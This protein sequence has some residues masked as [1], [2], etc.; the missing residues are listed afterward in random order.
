MMV[1]ACN[2][3]EVV[4]LREDLIRVAHETEVLWS[5]YER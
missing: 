4:R 3:L 5:V 1:M 2:I